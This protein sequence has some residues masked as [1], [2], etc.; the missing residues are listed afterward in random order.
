MMTK[1]IIADD[2]QIIIDGLK[3]LLQQEEQFQIIAEVSNG[4]A[5]IDNGIALQPDLILMDIGM[6]IMNGI[7]AAKEIKKSHPDIKIL[8]LTTY[9]DHKNIKEMLRIGVDGYILKDSGKDNFI[10]AI[11]T[12]IQGQTYYDK[13]VTEVLMNSFNKKKSTFNTPTPLTVREKQ[14]IQLIAEG[15]STLQISETLFLSILTVETHRKNI[16]T[17]LGLNKVATLVRYAVE[18]GI[19]E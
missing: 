1:I 14:I 18:E 9:A 11:R 12:I 5:L 16:Y 13:R 3:A 19:I 4:K 8:V 6:P 10:T 7:K 15:M 2:H 17:K